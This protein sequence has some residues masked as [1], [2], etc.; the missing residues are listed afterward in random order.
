M[1][2]I[3]DD[4]IQ[5]LI[6]EAKTCVERDGANRGSLADV[7]TLIERAAALPG[8]WGPDRYPDPD[9]GERQAR[10]LIATDPDDSFTLYLNVMRPGNRIPPHNHTTW[11][12]IAAVEGAEHNTL[13]ERTDG[14]TGAGPA[15]LHATG[16]VDVRPGRGIALLADDIHSV[17]IRGEK[18]IRHLHFYG[19][20]LE[21]L[22]ERLMFDLDAGEAQPMKMAVA[23]KK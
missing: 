20:A 13:Y 21:T 5:A 19:K 14:H 11:A 18:P 2:S 7:L 22:T 15:T 12:C 4:E 10:Y 8:R 6:V 9:T 23:T 16:E 1:S 3:A 17:E